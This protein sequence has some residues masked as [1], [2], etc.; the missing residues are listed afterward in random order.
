MAWEKSQGDFLESDVVEWVEAIWSPNKTRKRK[1]S[2]P[3]GKQK[4]IAQIA[5]IDGDFVK[6]TILK[7]HITENI[8]GSELRPHKVGSTITKKRSTLLRAETERL[9]WSEEDVRAALLT[10]SGSEKR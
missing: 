4:V 10:Q 5:A 2:R 3:W 9:L 6:L 7:A 8:I 1:K